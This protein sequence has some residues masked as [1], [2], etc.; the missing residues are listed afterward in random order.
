MIQLLTELYE[1]HHTT[2][3]CRVHDSQN[4]CLLEESPVSNMPVVSNACV[5]N[6]KEAAA[7]RLFCGPVAQGRALPG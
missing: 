6:D 7:G 4:I 5:P 1:P 3:I 2:I